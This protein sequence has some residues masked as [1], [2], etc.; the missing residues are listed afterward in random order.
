MLNKL[1]VITVF[2]HLITSVLL[3]KGPSAFFSSSAT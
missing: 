1:T 3:V 2:D